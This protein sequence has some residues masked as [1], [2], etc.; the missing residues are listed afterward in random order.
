M[1]TNELAELYTTTPRQLRRWRAAGI[2]VL[3][4]RAVLLHLGTARNGGEILLRLTEPGRVEE[5][6]TQLSKHNA[7]MV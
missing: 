1:T 5:I 4:P 2:D 7:T 6:E 3:N